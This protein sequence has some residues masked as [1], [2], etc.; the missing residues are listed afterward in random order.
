MALTIIDPLPEKTNW[1]LDASVQE[2]I[3]LSSPCL[4][5]SAMNCTACTVFLLS[6]VS[7]LDSSWMKEPK[8][9]MNAISATFDSGSFD[10][11]MPIGWP[12]AFSLGAASRT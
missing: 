9:I 6:I 2:K 1:L 4:E 7:A 10:C 11:P 8:H 3:W 12:A 5:R